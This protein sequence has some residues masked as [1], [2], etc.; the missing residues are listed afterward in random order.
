VNSGIKR[1]PTA[2]I[3][4]LQ[5][6]AAHP[7][8][9]GRSTRSTAKVGGVT[10]G[11]QSA[12]KTVEDGQNILDDVRR[13]ELA[14]LLLLAH[15]ALARIVEFRLQRPSDRAVR[16]VPPSVL[17]SDA[18]A[19]SAAMPTGAEPQILPRLPLPKLVLRSTFPLVFPF[20]LPML[21]T[22]SDSFKSL[23]NSARYTTPPTCVLIIQPRR[24]NHGQRPHHFAADAPGAPIRTNSAN[25]K[26]ASPR[27]AQS[28]RGPPPAAY[29]DR[30][31]ATHNLSFPQASVAFL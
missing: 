7:E 19:F 12:L 20:P 11:F 28:L 31:L 4:A 17:V 25:S 2:A 13:G 24:P 26:P 1:L 16:R 22:Y 27:R 8:T 18:A 3:A 6:S 29:Q 10:A 15:R 21:L 14:K 30:R 9:G 23:S 5:F